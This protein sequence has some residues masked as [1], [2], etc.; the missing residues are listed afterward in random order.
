[1]NRYVPMSGTFTQAGV[2]QMTNL[3]DLK[4]LSDGSGRDYYVVVDNGGLNSSPKRK[5]YFVSGRPSNQQIF[6]KTHT[7]AAK[8]VHYKSDGTGR[9]SYICKTDGGFTFPNKPC[10]PRETFK[11]QVRRYNKLDCYQETRNFHLSTK[12][13]ATFA[14]L[15]QSNRSRTLVD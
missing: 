14:R 12:F 7:D 6:R 11:N 2:N 10:D 15:A 1:M 9:D 5:E 13:G 3:R 8:L 4:Y